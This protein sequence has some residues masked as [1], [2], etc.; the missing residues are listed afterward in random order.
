MSEK[1]KRERL[2][3][4]VALL[5]TPIITAYLFIAFYEAGFSGYFSIP[6]ELIDINITDVILTNRLTLMVAVIAFLWIGLYYN[7]LPSASSPIFKGMVTFIL[8]L[9]LWLG[10]AF[11]N[12][13][14]KSKEFY[15]VTPSQPPKAVLKIYGDLIIL[16]PINRVQKTFDKNFTI[17]RAGEDTTS[18][19]RLERIGPLTV[20]GE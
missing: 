13:D 10:F 14:A 7:L 16:A 9:S 18:S 17:L 3:K 1:D 4:E 12:S 5:V 15:L 11:G 8:L 20:A 19:F 2:T 6:V